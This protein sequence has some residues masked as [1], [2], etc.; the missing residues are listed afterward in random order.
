VDVTRYPEAEQIPG[1]LIFRPNGILF[2]ANA[3]RIHNRITDLV[4]SAGTSLRTVLINLEASPE[5]DVTSLEMLVQTRKELRASGIDLNFA[6]VSDPVRDLF[7]RSGFAK[8][9]DGCLFR[10]VNVAVNA[11]LERQRLVRARSA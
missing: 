8:E 5:V 11:F 6:R 4:K 1:L 2:F 10:R 7:E 9:L 3:N